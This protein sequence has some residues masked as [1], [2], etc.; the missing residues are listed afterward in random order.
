MVLEKTLESSLDCRRSN[1]SI[2]KKKKNQSWIFTGRNDAEAEAPII[3]SYDG[4]NWLIGK[5]PDIRKDWR[6]EEKRK[7]GWDGWMASPNQWTW[8]WARTGSWWWIGKPGMMQSMALQRDGHNWRTELN[9]TNWEQRLINLIASSW[10]CIT[11]HYI[12]GFKIQNCDYIQRGISS[13]EKQEYCPSKTKPKKIKRQTGKKSET[14]FN[15][16]LFL[17]TSVIVTESYAC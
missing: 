1:L 5:D 11:T 12:S 13:E 10:W 9:W 17:I 14:I 8:A 7:T 16:I 15:N 2:L 6:Q 4:K 3:C